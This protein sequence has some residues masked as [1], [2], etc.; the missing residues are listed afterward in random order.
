M[1][2]IAAL[3]RVYVIGGFSTRRSTV[4]TCGAGAGRDRGVV[5]T[6]RRP[7]VSFVAG[8]TALCGRDVICCFSARASTVVAVCARAR[9]DTG[10]TEARRR[11]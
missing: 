6:R 9:R 11:K 1:A 8:V 10:V 7:R 4:V 3:R 5:E 2:R